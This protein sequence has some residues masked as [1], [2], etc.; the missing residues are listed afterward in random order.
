MSEVQP[1]RLLILCT[2]LIFS[3]KIT[4]TAKSL[5]VPFAVVRTLEKLR[6]QLAAHPIATFIVDL[7]ADRVNAIEAVRVAK[8]HAPSPR[9]V[10]FLSHVQVELAQEA[11]NAGADEV[12]ARSGF[13]AQLPAIVTAAK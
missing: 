12:L 5:G 4:G 6:E 1:V 7:N 9:V 10:A 8:A 2:D 3:T 13:V 11:G